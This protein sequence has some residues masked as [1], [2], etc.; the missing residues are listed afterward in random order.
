[1]VGQ[2]VLFSNYTECYCTAII[3]S[4]RKG[5]PPAYLLICRLWLRRLS[6]S[7]PASCLSSLTS[8]RPGYMELALGPGKV[9]PH[10]TGTGCPPQMEGSVV[11]LS[12][13]ALKSRRFSFTP[14]CLGKGASGPPRPPSA[15]RVWVR[16]IYPWSFLREGGSFP[17]VPNN[18]LR[19]IIT[20]INLCISS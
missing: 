19:A 9:L 2:E 1:M 7:E 15:S 20:E 17:S 11:W 10:R 6:E 13:N 16:S 14:R 12:E 18:R 8:L 3:S 5:A 4:R